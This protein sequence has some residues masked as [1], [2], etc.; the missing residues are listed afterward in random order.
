MTTK[1]P[2]LYADVLWNTALLPAFIVNTAT[3][4]RIDKK[5]G[6][7]ASINGVVW[8]VPNP[9]SK[10]EMIDGIN[11]IITFECYGVR[12]NPGYVCTQNVYDGVTANNIPSRYIV[13][14]GTATPGDSF[15]ADQLQVNGVGSANADYLQT[16]WRSPPNYLPGV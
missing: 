7:A 1:Y 5:A 6:L 10:L 2:G 15:K 16:D 8:D 11:A 3:G 12:I 14:G 4:A 9:T 13:M